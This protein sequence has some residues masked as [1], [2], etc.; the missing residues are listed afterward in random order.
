MHRFALILMVLLPNVVLAQSDGPQRPSAAIQSASQ[1]P[2][3]A[4]SVPIEPSGGRRV[5]FVIDCVSGEPSPIPGFD[6]LTG[7]RINP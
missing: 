5:T 3:C 6:G 1:H 4:V 7:C 2:S